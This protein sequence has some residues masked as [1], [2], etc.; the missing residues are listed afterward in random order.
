M[1]CLLRFSD[2]PTVATKVNQPRRPTKSLAAKV[3]FERRHRIYIY[4]ANNGKLR[5]NLRQQVFDA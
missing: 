1:V 5:L 4:L 3:G 2:Y